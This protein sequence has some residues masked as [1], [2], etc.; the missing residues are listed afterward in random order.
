MLSLGAIIP[1]FEISVFTKAATLD[2]VALLSHHVFKGSR[3]VGEDL[4][5]CWLAMLRWLQMG[6]PKTNLEVIR[7]QVPVCASRARD[8]HGAF[9]VA[10]LGYPMRRSCVAGL[11]GEGHL[12][13]RDLL[14]LLRRGGVVAWYDGSGF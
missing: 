5:P 8:Q 11:A 6:Q 13:L 14:L 1:E 2:Q 3:L 12:V 7:D 9:V 10:L 4:S